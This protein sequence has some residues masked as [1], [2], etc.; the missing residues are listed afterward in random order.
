MIAYGVL[1]TTSSGIAAAEPQFPDLNAF[2]SVDPTAFGDPP[3]P[4]ISFATPDSLTCSF[5]V[6]D[7]MA[8]PTSNQSLACR[9]HFPGADIKPPKDGWCE[10]KIVNNAAGFVY[11]FSSETTECKFLDAKPDRSAKTLAPG[12][13]ISSANI[14]CAVGAGQ[15]TACLDTRAGTRHGFVLHPS[16]SS[17]F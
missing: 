5:Y 11:H 15:L 1:C 7:K 3:G 6:A 14:T 10:Y 9:G 16:G 17:A 12:S 2:T 8:D 4:M 13:K